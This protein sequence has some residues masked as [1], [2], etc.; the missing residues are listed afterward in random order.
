MITLPYQWLIDYG[1]SIVGMNH[2]YI[3]G[4]RHL[5][6]A[7]TRDNICIKAEHKQDLEVFMTLKR[8]AKKFDNQLGTS[9]LGE[10]T[11]NQ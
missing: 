4:E 2:Y 11:N 6:C 8:L 7:M 5:F 1:W 9:K 3:N 10:A